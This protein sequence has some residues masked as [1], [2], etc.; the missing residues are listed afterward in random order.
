MQVVRRSYAISRTWIS[1]TR[2]KPPPT[3]AYLAA[4]AR[5]AEKQAQMRPLGLVV[6]INL[7]ERKL[8]VTQ[9]LFLILILV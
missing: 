8:N 6:M 1:V 9:K 3:A 5:A 4:V 7:V 2:K